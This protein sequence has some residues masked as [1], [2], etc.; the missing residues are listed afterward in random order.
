M[1]KLYLEICTHINNTMLLYFWNLGT[2]FLYWVVVFDNMSQSYDRSHNTNE[3]KTNFSN[4]NP[5]FFWGG[6][7]FAHT[8]Q[9]LL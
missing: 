1:K 5:I 4:F 7:I 3:E 8:L 6:V 2:I 9:E